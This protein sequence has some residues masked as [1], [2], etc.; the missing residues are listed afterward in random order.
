MYHSIDVAYG[1]IKHEDDYDNDCDS[2]HGDDYND[3]KD[4]D[5]D[6]NNN[7]NNR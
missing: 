4:N 5:D 7:N 6:D 1:L 2:G 3:D